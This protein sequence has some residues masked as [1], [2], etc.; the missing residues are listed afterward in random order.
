MSLLIRGARGCCW[1]RGFS[2]VA[3]VI[4]GYQ[5]SPNKSPIKPLCEQQEQRGPLGPAR[6]LC[7]GDAPAAPVVSRGFMEQHLEVQGLVLSYCP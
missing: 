3:L 7:A 1:A 4:L 6:G 2:A 5:E